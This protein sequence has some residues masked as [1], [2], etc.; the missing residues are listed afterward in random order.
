MSLNGWER[1]VEKVSDL[2]KRRPLHIANIWESIAN[3]RL[4]H[5]SVEH[6]LNI[7]YRKGILFWDTSRCLWVAVVAI[8][9]FRMRWV[10]RGGGL[11]GVWSMLGMA[12]AVGVEATEA[13][14]RK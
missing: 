3:F 5:L 9:V 4:V 1:K 8:K 6:L 14:C 10:G 7:Y 2:L 13:S 12:W 11:T